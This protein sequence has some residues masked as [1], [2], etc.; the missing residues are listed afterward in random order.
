MIY[1]PSVSQAAEMAEQAPTLAAFVRCEH[2]RATARDNTR[3]EGP[4]G[5]CSLSQP[6][7]DLTLEGKVDRLGKQPVGPASTA[8]R[9]V[10]AS[11]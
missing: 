5:S 4:W 10:S 9:V 2:Y 8:L 7:V 3:P 11:P 6:R 1:A